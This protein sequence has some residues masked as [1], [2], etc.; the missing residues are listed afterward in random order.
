MFFLPLLGYH[1]GPKPSSFRQDGADP[2]SC[3][4]RVGKVLLA[5]VENHPTWGYELD[6]D[7]ERIFKGFSRETEIRRDAEGRWFLEGDPITHRGLVRAFDGWLERAEDGRYCLKNSLGWAYV[8]VEGCPYFVRGVQ[9]DGGVIRL[10]LS[11]GR[12]DTLHPETLHMGSDGRLY[13]MVF[14]GEL[15]ARFDDSAAVQMGECLEEEADGFQLRIGDHVWPI[16]VSSAV[17]G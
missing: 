9:R 6:V 1:G 4:E 3:R 13:A 11:G 10:S 14:E 12:R 8:Q 15:R 16:P 7:A 5:V 2:A 17:D